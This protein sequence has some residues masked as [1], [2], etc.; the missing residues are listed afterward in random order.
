MLIAV[1]FAPVLTGLLFRFGIPFAESRLCAYF[2]AEAILAP[3]YLLFDL[4]LCIVTPY[5][6]CFV[7]ALVMLTEYDENMSSYLAVTPV[8]KRGYIMSRLMLPACLSFFAAVLMMALFSLNVWPLPLLLAACLLSCLLSVAVALLIFSLSHNRVEGMAMG[9]LS[10]LFL[11]GLFVPFFI[12]SWVQFLFSP[13]PSFWVAKLCAEADFIHL[14]P[15]LLTALLW[16]WALYRKF[17]KK[18]A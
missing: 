8:G 15:A 17:V 10:G 12:D 2:G 7:S 3:Y 5:I 13:L 4:F 9:K 14:L 18:L 11:L 16:I 1:C 6:F